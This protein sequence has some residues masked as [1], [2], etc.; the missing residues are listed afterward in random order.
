MSN[1]IASWRET[2]NKAVDAKS[3]AEMTLREEKRNKRNIRNRL[4]EVERENRDLKKKLNKMKKMAEIDKRAVDGQVKRA[5]RM[6]AEVSDAKRFAEIQDRR[7]NEAEVKLFTTSR[8]LD[9]ERSLRL[10]DLHKTGAYAKVAK[11]ADKRVAVAEKKERITQAKL[12]ESITRVEGLDKAIGVFQQ[13]EELHLGTIADADVDITVRDETITALQREV[14]KR[15]NALVAATR[16][17]QILEKEVFRLQGELTRTLKLN[18][19]LSV[20][21][22]KLQSPT[23]RKSVSE[24]GSSIGSAESTRQARPVTS[25]TLGRTLLMSQRTRKPSETPEVFIAPL[26]NTNP[27]RLGTS[28]GKSRSSLR[29]GSRLGSRTSTRGLRPGSSVRFAQTEMPALAMSA[30]VPLE[31]PGT[32]SMQSRPPG[33]P[34]AQN[35]D[36][37]NASDESSSVR[38]GSAQIVRK[39]H[40][41]SAP[42]GD[43]SRSGTA[44]SLDQFVSADHFADEHE[45]TGVST[46]QSSV[47]GGSH[48]P[49]TLSLSSTIN[50]LV[51]RI[52]PE[53][54]NHL[55][56]LS[57]GEKSP[58]PRKAKSRTCKARPKSQSLGVSGSLYVGSGLGM[59]K[60]PAEDDLAMPKGSAK[61]ILARILK[62]R[63]DRQKAL[64]EA[65]HAEVA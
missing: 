44:D 9:Q 11:T 8:V 27:D 18:T 58:P 19:T 53:P 57:A 16:S 37:A 26:L 43:R 51:D 54:Y 22:A 36:W 12:N 17:Q 6:E 34:G 61:Q 50:S 60:D 48:I 24:W 13:I 62:E 29:T 3:A 49:E 25:A 35:W 14:S 46:A 40:L 45:R 38:I 20:S 41:N 42:A 32:P 63:E 33:T 30:G 55:L 47:T 56:G 28:H 64:V 21:N 10:Q 23:F 1:E 65:A 15:D 5:R 52:D 39:Q 7:R 2:V 4:D 59:R 31:K